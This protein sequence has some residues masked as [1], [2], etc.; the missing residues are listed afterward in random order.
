MTVAELIIELQEQNPDSEVCLEG[1]GMVNDIARVYQQQIR[2]NPEKNK[3]QYK[4]ILCTYI[5][6]ARMSKAKR[7]RKAKV[8]RKR[9]RRMSLRRVT[10]KQRRIAYSFGNP[11][12]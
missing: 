8:M 12:H 9:I 11:I 7:L 3:P 4:V 6:Q 1:S 2:P 5:K 10:N